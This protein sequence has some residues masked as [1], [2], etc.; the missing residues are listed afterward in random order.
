M[1]KTWPPPP[2]PPPSFFE[3]FQKEGGSPNL[4][5]PLHRG[6]EIFQKWLWRGDGKFLLEMGG[7]PRMRVGNWFY[8]EGDEIRLDLLIRCYKTRFFLQSINNNDKNGVN[9]QNQWCNLTL[10]WRFWATKECLWASNISKICLFG[11]STRQATSWK[12]NFEN[13]SR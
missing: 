9:K 4:P 2:P 6:D 5:H 11:R 10:T 12:A 1:S 3:N 7:K 13:Y 8:N